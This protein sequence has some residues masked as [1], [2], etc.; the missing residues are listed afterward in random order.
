M[1]RLERIDRAQHGDP[2]DAMYEGLDARG[3]LLQIWVEIT[4]AWRSPEGAKETLEV[5]ERRKPARTGPHGLL[6][7]PD[8][9]TAESVAHAVCLKLQKK[10]YHDLAHNY[11]P[12]HL[13]VF[14]SSDHYPLFDAGTLVEIR[15]YL[16]MAHLEGQSVFRSV[17][18]GWNG[19][20]Y[21]VWNRSG[22]PTAARQAILNGSRHRQVWLRAGTRSTA[23]PGT[24]HDLPLLAVGIAAARETLLTATPHMA[25]IWTDLLASFLLEGESKLLW[26]DD[27]PGIG[28]DVRIAYSS[29][30]GRYLARAY[31]TEEQGVQTLV[32]IDV[33]KRSLKGTR[34]AITKRSSRGLEADWIG[35]DGHG[36][37]IVEAKGSFDS[38][39]GAWCG[40]SALPPTVETAIEQAERTILIDRDTGHQLR[41]ARWAVASRWGT[42]NNECE[43]TLLAVRDLGGSDLDETERAV[44]GEDYQELT[45][46]LLAADIEAVKDGLTVSK[47]GGQRI[48]QNDQGPLPIRIGEESLGPSY[49][50]AFGPFGWQPLRNRD[51]L[52][53]VRGGVRI[54]APVAVASLSHRYY[55]H[56]VSGRWSKPPAEDEKSWREDDSDLRG[57]SQVSENARGLVVERHGLTVAW[58]DRD[59]DIS[60]VP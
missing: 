5:A 56:I 47:F 11:G 43:P 44:E 8:E 17:S 6:A 37:V 1:R 18:V 13:H 52:E 41:A 60:L 50:A 39:I 12:G 14:V 35:F 33:A 26:R 31:L 24:P 34:F 9:T 59:E 42:E 10:S 23:I 51:D 58:L 54:G 22:A 7:G 30:L 25:S 46:V 20:T 4:G 21:L 15:L 53:M 55:Q 28:R 2:P 3:A 45:E 19:Q 27:G 29:L 48:T 32:P 57:R 16:L 38:R 36:L 49:S 40:P